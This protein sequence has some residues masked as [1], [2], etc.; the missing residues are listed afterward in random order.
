MHQ[1]PAQPAYLRVKLWRRLQ[2]IGAVPIKNGVHALPS[3]AE[4]LEDF[5]WL[6]REAV[7]GGG[8]A[9]IAEARLV[10]GLTDDELCAIFKNARDADYRTVIEEARNLQARIGSAERVRDQL[11]RL[12]LRLSQLHEI[13]FFEAPMRNAAEAAVH[14]AAAAIEEADKVQSEAR[15][16]FANLLG[17][18]WVTRSAVYVDRIASAWFVLRFI[19][20]E[21]RFNFVPARNYGAR[22]DEI[23]FDMFEAEFTHIGDACTM[24]VLA[25]Q[26]RSDDA[27]VRAIAEI[28][29]DIDLKDNKFGRPE[30]DGIRTLISGICAR[31]DDDQ[32]RIE[33][34]CQ[35]FD[36]LYAYF[37][38]PS[39]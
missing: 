29:H 20:P 26:F 18:T 28:V 16:S 14:A 36:D 24:E 32:Q 11:Q 31:T 23:R 21:A 7:S 15:Q 10:D 17:K 38:K 37:L 33:R 12:R 1:L 6:A 34:G 39:P 4:S 35:V 27:A 19:D 2:A 22:T 8:E 5:E 25:E 13:D 3:T 9:A 30:V